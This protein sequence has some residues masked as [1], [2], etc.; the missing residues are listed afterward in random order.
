VNIKAIN[1][2]NSKLKMIQMAISFHIL[3]PPTFTI[4][5]SMVVWYFGSE[6]R[7][8]IKS[9]IYLKRS[10]RQIAWH[11]LQLRAYLGNLKMSLVG[12]NNSKVAI[13]YQKLRNGQIACICYLSKVIAE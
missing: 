12:R 2:T 5:G 3:P 8:D 6:C 11:C 9:L 10:E 4:S 1:A 7:I 13:T